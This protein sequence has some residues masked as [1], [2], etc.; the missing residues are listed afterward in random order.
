MPSCQGFGSRNINVTN[1]SSDP[2]CT[3][4]SN[5]AE[6]DDDFKVTYTVETKVTDEYYEIESA[7]DGTYLDIMIS[8]KILLTI[9]KLRTK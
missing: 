6:S 9:A 1:V 3:T 2:H 5:T 4:D 7:Q 8:R